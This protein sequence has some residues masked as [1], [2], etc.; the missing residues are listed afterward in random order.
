[1]EMIDEMK[2]VF[3]PD[4]KSSSV[5]VVDNYRGNVTAEEFANR[6]GLIAVNDNDSDSLSYRFV[7]DYV[8]TVEAVED[9]IESVE[10][11]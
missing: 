5:L 7:G 11:R 10:Q 3:N 2:I 8:S 6:H 4:G 1:M 9:Y